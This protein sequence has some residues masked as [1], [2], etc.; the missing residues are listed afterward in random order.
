M[1]KKGKLKYQKCRK[2]NSAAAKKRM[3]E[4]MQFSQST[5]REYIIAAKGGQCRRCGYSEFTVALEFHH[6]RGEDKSS[7]ISR[8]ITQFCYGATPSQWDELSAE[9]AK[10]I[11]LCSN[12]HQALHNNAWIPPAKYYENHIPPLV[13][14]QK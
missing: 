7:G 13:M 9:A 10:C 3:R 4:R 12:C 11:I 1:T 14:P 8:L 5:I 2:C 6:L